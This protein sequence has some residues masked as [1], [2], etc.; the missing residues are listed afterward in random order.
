[1]NDQDT[2]SYEQ[3]EM[4]AHNKRKIMHEEQ[5]RDR[6]KMHRMTKNVDL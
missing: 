1:M 3:S 4:E 6:V 2:A 5:L